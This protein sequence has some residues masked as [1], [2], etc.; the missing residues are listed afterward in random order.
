MNQTQ[1]F[2]KIYSDF[3]NSRLDNDILKIRFSPT[4]ISGFFSFPHNDAYIY[5][6]YF[7]KQKFIK[8]DNVHLPSVFLQSL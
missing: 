7:L 5:F 8:E 3:R 4:F 1:F 6:K 2:I